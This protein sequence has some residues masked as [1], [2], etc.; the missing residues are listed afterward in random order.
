MGEKNS[1]GGVERRQSKR[2]VVQEAFSFFIVIPKRMGMSRVYMRDISASGLAF[3]LEVEHDFH[4]DQAFQ[5]RLYTSPAFYLPVEVKVV[6]VD[7][8]E[9][10]LAFTQS[11]S[12]GV[13][14]LQKF[15][16]FLD[17][18]SEAAVLEDFR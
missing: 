13:Q 6:R 10:A 16:E 8:S 9:V 2:I 14:A 17:L 7:G 15:I 1:K 18:A 12:K 3:Q 11:K 5:I 4:V